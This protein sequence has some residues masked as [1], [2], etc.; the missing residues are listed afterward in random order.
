MKA[1]GRDI[2][3]NKSFNQDIKRIFFYLRLKIWLYM[4]AVRQVI[5]GAGKAQDHKPVPRFFSNIVKST[6]RS[7]TS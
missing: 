4:I 3:F 6:S 2:F 7:G 1:L 5:S